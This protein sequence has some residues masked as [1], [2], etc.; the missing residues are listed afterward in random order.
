M[1]I[2]TPKEQAT[3][4]ATVLRVV[5]AQDLAVAHRIR[6]YGAVVLLCCCAVV[7]VKDAEGTSSDWDRLG[8]GVA[9]ATRVPM[10]SEKGS[11]FVLALFVTLT[12]TL[13]TKYI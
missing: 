12:R 5:R 1:E 4:R 3:T 9:A 2:L 10:A 6:L 11:G 8:T 13:T 7:R